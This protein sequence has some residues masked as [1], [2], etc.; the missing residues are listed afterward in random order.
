MVSFSHGIWSRGAIDLTPDRPAPRR[1]AAPASSPRFPLPLSVVRC[2]LLISST[3]SAQYP[4]Q[5]KY[6][7]AIRQVSGGKREVGAARRQG[8]KVR[9]RNFVESHA[10]FW[11]KVPGRCSTITADD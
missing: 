1:G 4:D 7:Q 11:A 5:Y 9:S 10:T 2:P 8:T 3:P 6:Q